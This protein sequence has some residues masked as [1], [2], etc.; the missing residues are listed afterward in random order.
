MARALLSPLP[1]TIKP[2]E[3]A[4][5]EARVDGI[6][7]Q[8]NCSRLAALAVADGGGD[9]VVS[10]EF[11]RNGAERPA[12]TGSVEA[13]LMLACQRCLEPVLTGVKGEVRAEFVVGDGEPQAEGFEA[14]NLDEETLSLSDF[15]EDEIL[16]ALPFAPTHEAGGCAVQETHKGVEAQTSPERV[17][18]FAQ[19]RDLLDKKS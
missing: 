4:A 19:L 12:C 1:K 18:P 15:V 16:L 5:R 6:I 9:V 13:D 11:A 3:L 14:V 10:L 8:R 17:K 7:A 2:L